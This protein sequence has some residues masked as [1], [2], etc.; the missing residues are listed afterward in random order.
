MGTKSKP[1]KFDCHDAA[2]PDEPR[3]TLLARDQSAP[4]LVR[5][6]AAKRAHMIK[7]G[8]APAEDQAKIDEARTLAREMQVWRLAN[9]GKWRKAKTPEPPRA[10]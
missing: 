10:A 4:A 2:L 8:L 6:W 7:V 1:G 5:D 3:F 9:P